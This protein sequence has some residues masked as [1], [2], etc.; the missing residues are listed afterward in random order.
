MLLIPAN[1]KIYSQTI[2]L[3]I[4]DAINTALEN[5]PN[6]K[7]GKLEIEKANAA[8]REAY[9]YAYPS[10]D[11]SSS[12]SHFIEKPVMPFP[13]FEAL[14]GNATYGILFNE[15]VLPYDPSKFKPIDNKLQS[16]ALANNFDATAQVTQILFNSAVFNGIGASQIYLNLSKEQLKATIAQNVLDVKKAFYGVLLTK[17][18]LEIL[19]A[20]LDN[21]IKNLD[22]IK[23][24][25][26]EGLLSD[27]DRMQVEVQVENIRPQVTQ[28]ENA[29]NDATDGLKMIIGIDPQQ[30][31]EVI[32]NLSYEE[33]SIPDQSATI[34]E[35]IDN[36]YTLQTLKIKRDID[37][38]FIDL[39]LAGYW[40]T[41]AAFGNYT[42][43]GQSDD[44]NFLT[45]NQSMVGISFSIN[46]F[47]GFQTQNK[48]QQS[49]I[50]VK[51]T[52]E[53]IAQLKD[54][55]KM[56]IISK[57]N[58]LAKV[59]AMME[60]QQRNVELAQKTYD[61]SLVRYKEGTST[62]LEVQNS[63]MALRQA[64]SNMLQSVYEYIVS[65]AEL[66]QLTGNV[67]NKYFEKF[68]ELRD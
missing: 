62:Q 42:Y 47:K 67:E 51:Q 24:M 30:P 13:D 43:A 63:D 55:T 60:A 12:F 18:M 20:S 45:Y 41:L 53:Q 56:Q 7:I 6:M 23:A 22:N 65:S 39:D 37:E 3:T 64:R 16:F 27:Y 25:Q 46:L 52:D 15:N 2:K 40:P 5:N 14:L 54:F 36:N 10:L 38:A 58:N 68:E 31:V 44:L 33:F 19:R 32:G 28:L 34:N 59:K 11:F 1:E 21:A 35:A 66:E 61:I 4:D 29:L 17:E 9:G 8:V 49:Q 57:I 26:K 50:A 48:V